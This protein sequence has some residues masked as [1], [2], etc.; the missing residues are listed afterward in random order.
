MP[1]TGFR[2]RPRWLAAILHYIDSSLGEPL[3][4]P[5]LAAHANISA[6]HLAHAF[7]K[8]MG[9]TV[10]EYIRIARIRAAAAALRES[11]L[12]IQEIAYRTGFYDQAHFCRAFKAE[13]GV[14]PSDY[15]C[16]DSVTSAMP[17][18]SDPSDCAL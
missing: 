6:S 10:G 12:R 14:T 2:S 11:D 17:K 3:S 8:V 9:C 5:A 13:H 15:R 7:P 16:H 18:H 4:I 1:E